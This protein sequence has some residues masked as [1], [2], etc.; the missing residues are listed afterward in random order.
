VLNQWRRKVRKKIERNKIRTNRTV[1]IEIG[2]VCRVS[3][4]DS[5]ADRMIV[6]IIGSHPTPTCPLLTSLRE[7]VSPPVACLSHGGSSTFTFGS[8][9]LQMMK[10]P[11]TVEV[12][13]RSSGKENIPQHGKLKFRSRQRI[14]YSKIRV[15]KNRMAY[16]YFYEVSSSLRITGFLT[17]SIV[18]YS[19]N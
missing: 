18:R 7:A 5:C 15:G 6:C 10:K 4:L 9:P 2:W 1:A 17:L 16:V 19:R 11:E 13:T 12:V 3:G 8:V 14:S